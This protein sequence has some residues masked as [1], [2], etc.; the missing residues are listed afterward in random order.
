MNGITKELKEELDRKNQDF[1]KQCKVAEPPVIPEGRLKYAARVE[2]FRRLSNKNQVL[3][4]SLLDQARKLR[5][6]CPDAGCGGKGYRHATDK[7]YFDHGRT[8]IECDTCHGTGTLPIE[9]GDVDIVKMVNAMN[10]CV[11]GPGCEFCDGCVIE[12]ALSGLKVTP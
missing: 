3:A 8:T 1:L 7:E 6:V 5:K 2:I 9:P 4:L 10:K 11:N 12:Q